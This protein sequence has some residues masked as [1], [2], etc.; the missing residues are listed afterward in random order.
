MDKEGEEGRKD[1]R[2]KEEK[3]LLLGYRAQSLEEERKEK[4]KTTVYSLLK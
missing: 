1:R 4:V 2:E 3:N